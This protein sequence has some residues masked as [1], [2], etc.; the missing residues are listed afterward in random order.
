MK[1][2]L[3]CIGEALID[4]INNMKNP[5]GAPLN[6]ACCASVYNLNVGFIG[7]I[8]NDVE[9][10]ILLK[11]MNDLNINITN[12]IID[13]IHPTTQAY[14]SLNKNGD[15]SFSF[16]RE[17]SADIFLKKNELNIEILQNTKVLHF[18]SL[19]LVNKTYEEAT[20]EA[21]NTAKQ[22]NAIIS[23][24]PNYRE[25][26]W[27]S[28]NEAINKMCRY[29]HLVDILKIS[30]DELYLISNQAN[31][32]DALNYISKYNIKIILITDSQNGAY[33]YFNNSII[34]IPTIKVNPIDTTAAGDT[35][36]GTF[37]SLFIINNKSLDNMTLE[38]I[39]KYTKTACVNASITTTYI[40]GIPSILKLKKYND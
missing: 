18:G 24:D 9:G 33:I 6:V 13:N 27:N 22:N 23:Y 21:I 26:L 12:V 30:L 14:V 8:G 28:K 2:D 31:L 20:I 32:N 19:S 7:K 40:G 15:R 34:N 11:Q 38:E 5:G 4:N 25:L 3:L 35:F 37:L 29:L 16:N 17:N 36:I 39:I 1:F 10:K